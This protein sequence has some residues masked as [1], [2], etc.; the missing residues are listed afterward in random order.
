[1]LSQAHYEKI[2]EAR[3]S[4]GWLLSMNNNMAYTP[5]EAEEAMIKAKAGAAAWFIIDPAHHIDT[6][7]IQLEAA[8][9][10][11]NKMKEK[12]AAWSKQQQN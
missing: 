11:L 10:R 6:Q 9:I 3:N 5:D 12:F 8:Q 7:E 1:M 4:N 2:K